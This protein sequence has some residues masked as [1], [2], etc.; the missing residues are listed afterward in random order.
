MRPALLPLLFT[1]LI[2]ALVSCRQDAAPDTL[3]TEVPA[4][5]S[6]I[7]FSNTIK[8]DKDYNILTY[9]YLYNGGGVAAGDVNN[10]GLTDLV[11]SG[12]M[13]PLRLYL[14]KGNFRF[15][16]VTARAGFSNRTRWRTGVVMAD[17]NGDG[18]LDIYVCY[19][20]PGSDADR[21]NEL[22]INDGLKD[23][24][25]HF[26]ESAK[27]YGLDAP[28][29]FTTTVAFFDMDNDG[30]LDMF[31]VNHGDMFFNPDFNTDKLRS[32]RNPKFGNRL[33]RNDGG[34]FTD[35]SDPAHIDGSGLNFG[36]SVAISDINNDGWPDIYVTN[37]YDE[38]DFLYLNDH[39]GRFHEVLGTAASHI[40][41]FAMG[42]DIADYNNDGKTDVFVLDML[43]ED[44]HRQKLLRGGNNY[45][46][47]TMRAQHG[48]HRQ[49]MRNTLQLNNGND[50]S[51]TPIF[52]EIGQMAGISATDWSWS[53]LL[54]DFDN[55]G[56]K[57][58]FI[59]NGILRDMTNLDFVKYTSGYSNDY[60]GKTAS[61]DEM[62]ELVKNM[63]STKLN[64]YVF[65]NNH[66]LSFTDKSVEWGL[67]HRSVSNG[68]VYADLDNDGDL[69]LVINNLND[70]AT[71]YRNNTRERASRP[72]PGKGPVPKAHWL[73][74]R[75][76]GERKNSFGLGAKVHVQSAGGEQWQEQYTSRGFQSSVDP[77][78]HIGLGA[79]SLVNALEVRWPGG[80]ISRLENLAADTLLVIREKD[81]MRED[82]Q[83]PKGGQAPGVKTALF[84][85]ITRS[86]GVD[87]VHQQATT[88]DF[89]IAPL[90]PYQISRVG[91]CLAK[92]DVNGDGREDFFVGGS[93]GYESRLYLQVADGK[94]VMAPDQPWNLDKRFTNTDAL[95][96]DADGDGD[97]DLY[98]VSGGADYPLNSKNYQDRFF[99]NTG[100]GHF[101]ELTDA[102][103]AETISGGCVRTADFNRDGR[104]D[105]FVGGRLNPGLF[106]GAPESLVLKNSSS[107]GHI[108]FE[109]DAAQSDSLLVHPGMVTDAVWLDL[110]KDGWPDLVL[111]GQFMP[112]TIFENDKGRLRDKTAAYGLSDTR[113]WWSRL[114]ALDI[115]GDGDTDLVAG[116]LGLNTYFKASP[117]GPMTIYSSDFNGD[118]LLD[119]VLCLYNKGKEYPYFSRDEL[120]EQI[121]SLQ[122]KIAR[123]ADYA[124]AQMKDLFSPGQ[125]AAAHTV[126]IDRLES[127]CL[128]R[129]GKEK[130]SRHPLPEYAQMSILNGIL[131]YKNSK[132]GP[133]GLIVSGNFYPMRAQMGPLDAG[134]GLVLAGDGKGG[135]IPEP[136]ARTGLCIRGDIRD[137]VRVKGR[138]GSVIIAA[139][140]D[141]PIQVI[142]E[143]KQE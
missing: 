136:Y 114:L 103:P 33:Y 140:N 3:F 96:F 23:G 28:G 82:G 80:A 76:A 87:Y 138:S 122:K 56:W 94:F 15:E 2:P 38:R 60:T 97:L 20:G 130:W 93:A 73:R 40:S 47:Y 79:D 13:V 143:L 83:E 115:N 65:H 71:I 52:S 63:P 70:A 123:Y 91:P 67:S 39:H 11:F 119:P 21:A 127:L 102:L 72:L 32:T 54:A 64:N 37:D 121:P 77:I 69:D 59:S 22:Y 74:L 111:A 104:P 126:G 113:G 106:P 98:L 95:F 58:L 61:K 120:L 135:F 17:V 41:E 35:I 128:I 134:I 101:K 141:G 43:P 90:L 85:D 53:P 105:L 57:D 109:K 81:A 75:L 89:K 110:N 31:M 66:D 7:D 84:T 46:K 45:D 36:L 44:N 25:P 62:W 50:S 117:A 88:V 125:L 10:D 132:D 86:S 142:R 18:L 29:T 108:R 34:V 42:S 4:E 92:G 129:E 49:Q 131:P 8:E 27:K 133:A 9:E 78:M 139:A 51:G 12:N 107:P 6:H 116:N 124:D 112:I 26:T 100:N 55:D 118:G 48:F 30:D 137:M 1:A 24:V 16:D 14:N 99:E 19:S 68:A 5:Q